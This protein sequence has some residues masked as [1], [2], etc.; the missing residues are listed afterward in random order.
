MPRAVKVKALGVSGPKRLA[1]LPDVP[2]IAEA[3]LPGYE[4]ILW[5]GFFGPAAL[6]R[7]TAAK[8]AADL[9]RVLKLPDVQER[10]AALGVE[11]VGSSPDEFATFVKSEIAK[12]EK[13]KKATGLI[14][15]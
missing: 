1:A 10:F 5:Y 15:D 4:V 8:I 12:W 9:A 3:G 14:I 11:P 2:T 13:V 7:E 6:P